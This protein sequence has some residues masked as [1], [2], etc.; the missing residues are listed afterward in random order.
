MLGMSSP[1]LCG[2]RGTRSCYSWA[3]EG[4]MEL[5]QRAFSTLATDSQQERQILHPECDL[6]EDAA[7]RDS[8]SR[9]NK[10]RENCLDAVSPIEPKC[11]AMC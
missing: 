3:S 7:H 8:L 9:I 10:Y 4:E 2:E 1:Q 6:A 5:I 11:F